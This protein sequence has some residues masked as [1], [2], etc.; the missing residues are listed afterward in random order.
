MSSTGYIPYKEW[1]SIKSSIDWMIENVRVFLRVGLRLISKFI[2]LL[3]RRK[4]SQ[5][6][7]DVCALSWSLIL[8]NIVQQQITSLKLKKF[9]VWK[10]DPVIIIRI[11]VIF[12]KLTIVRFSEMK[13]YHYYTIIYFRWGY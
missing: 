6:T 4:D 2:A 11:S 13:N 3:Y 7:I 5:N 1:P 8:H 9:P 10:S 12:Y